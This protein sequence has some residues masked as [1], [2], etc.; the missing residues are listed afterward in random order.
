MSNFDDVVY[1][2]G[3]LE[4]SIDEL[5]S[6]EVNCLIDKIDDVQSQ[7][8]KAERELGYLEDD[9]EELERFRELG[10]VDDLEDLS[11]KVADLEEDLETAKKAVVDRHTLSL[12][13]EHENLKKHHENQRRTIMALLGRLRYARETLSEA[14]IVKLMSEASAEPQPERQSNDEADPSGHGGR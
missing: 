11:E 1:A 13:V 7:L 3:N 4:A 9:F 5:L 12:H 6:T 14:E 8:G 2:M 10:D